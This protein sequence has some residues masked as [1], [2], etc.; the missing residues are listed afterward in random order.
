MLVAA[1]AWCHS[2]S[3]HQDADAWACWLQTGACL[4]A[5]P[6]EAQVVRLLS[7][8]SQSGQAL[9]WFKETR[10]G[11]HGIYIVFAC[12]LAEHQSHDAAALGRASKSRRMP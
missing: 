9:R 2:H 7:S 11:Q 8:R 10:G 1:A 5:G 4:W 6:A 3:H 12:Y